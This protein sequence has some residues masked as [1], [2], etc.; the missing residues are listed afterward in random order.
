[1]IHLVCQEEA[2]MKVFGGPPPEQNTIHRSKDIA[3]QDCAAWQHM[4]T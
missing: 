3:W 1:M 4:H 2:T